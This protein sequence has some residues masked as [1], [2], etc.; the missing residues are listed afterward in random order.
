[1][2]TRTG[3][4]PIDGGRLHVVAGTFASQGVSVPPPPPQGQ[5]PPHPTPP[6]VP[7]VASGVPPLVFPPPPRADISPC[8]S[9]CVPS[10]G[11][12]S[13]Q[14]TA[15]VPPHVPPLS[16]GPASLWASPRSPPQCPPPACVPH[17]PVSSP[18]TSM[19]PESLQVTTC[20]PPLCVPPPRGG[21]ISGCLCVVSPPSPCPQLPPPW[22]KGG[23]PLSSPPRPD[24]AGLSLCVGTPPPVGMGPP[25]TW[26]KER[27]PLHYP[28]LGGGVTPP[29]YLWGDT[30]SHLGEGDFRGGGV[31]LESHLCKGGTHR[32]TPPPPCKALHRL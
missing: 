22:Q 16:W 2:G 14:A 7:H 27:F 9:P 12:L 6:R 3:Y 1:M 11:P 17:V 21:G 25:P 5:G 20:V 31:R 24:R 26:P 30:V 8:G 10:M 15:C 4:D 19:G 13:L 29:C 18:P 28:V 32:R 23:C